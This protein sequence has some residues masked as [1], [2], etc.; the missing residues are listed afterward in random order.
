[1]PA[2][3][4]R[5]RPPEWKPGSAQIPATSGDIA[6]QIEHPSPKATDGA[7][8]AIEDRLQDHHDIIQ[9]AQQALDRSQ[10]TVRRGRIL[11]PTDTALDASAPIVSSLEGTIFSADTL[12]PGSSFKSVLRENAS[13]LHLMGFDERGVLEQRTIRARKRPPEDG[14][15][16]VL[17]RDKHD[18][19]SSVTKY[20]EALHP[21]GLNPD[22]PYITTSREK[23][24]T[25]TA[26][27]FTHEGSRISYLR[28]PQGLET[29]FPSQ[30]KP[31]QDV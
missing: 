19:S 1:M 14:D 4:D 9:A 28:D 8:R 13:D 22:H 7:A 31:Q 6:R 27:F 5:P 21:H 2:R 10:P 24:G 18:G 16:I 15:D 17:F 3:G 23:D 11:G 30:L 20:Q 25:V 12:V 29:F 26:T